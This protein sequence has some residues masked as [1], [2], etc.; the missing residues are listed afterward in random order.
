MFWLKDTRRMLRLWGADSHCKFG[1][2][3]EHLLST[4]R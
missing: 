2:L 4:E 1:P 3:M